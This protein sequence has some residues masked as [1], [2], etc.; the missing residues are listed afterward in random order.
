MPEAPELEN[1][2]GRNA[3]RSTHEAGVPLHRLAREE[4]G[5]ATTFPTCSPACTPR[6][7]DSVAPAGCR[8]THEAAVPLQRLACCTPPTSA[9]PTCWMPSTPKAVD[10]VAPAGL[11]FTH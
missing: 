2:A 5:N 9:A 8:S 7:S 4:F 1:P 11:R 3:C 6:A 10:H